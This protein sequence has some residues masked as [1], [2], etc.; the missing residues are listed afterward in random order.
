MT[1]FDKPSFKEGDIVVYNPESGEKPIWIH[2]TAAYL[3]DR[4]WR[5]GAGVWYVNGEMIDKSQA[6]KMCHK[7]LNG[8]YAFRFMLPE[9]Q[10]PVKV[11]ELPTDGMS[12]KQIL[13]R[14][15]MLNAKGL[16]IHEYK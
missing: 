8:A 13:D 12:L 3:I 5:V 2:P 6:R 10:H 11:S 7:T 9:P 1:P 4:V 16:I 14:Y 15:N